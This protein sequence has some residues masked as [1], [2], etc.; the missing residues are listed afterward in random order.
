[1]I[2]DEVGPFRRF[3]PSQRLKYCPVLSTQGCGQ[4]RPVRLPAHT[5]RHVLLDC[6][7]QP[8][9]RGL[10]QRVSGEGHQLDVELGVESLEFLNLNVGIFHLLENLER[11]VE[12]ACNSPSS[13]VVR[14]VDYFSLL[15]LFR[16]AAHCHR[17]RGPRLD[18][19]AHLH[20]VPDRHRTGRH[21]EPDRRAEPRGGLIN[22]DRACVGAGAR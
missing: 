9:H 10:K 17:S 12:A 22:Q 14:L 7:A 21:V 6:L 19:E 18:Q 15:K 16:R 2:F 13:H 3:S 20:H 11:R 8:Q 1:M 5:L 4:A